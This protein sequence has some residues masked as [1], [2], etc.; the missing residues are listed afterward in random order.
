MKL[1]TLDKIIAL[2]FFL[3]LALMLLFFFKGFSHAQVSQVANPRVRYGASFSGGASFKEFSII[4]AAYFGLQ[5]NQ[6]TISPMPQPTTGFNYGLIRFWDFAGQVEVP[7]VFPTGTAYPVATPGTPSWSLFDPWM[8][9]AKTNN[10][11]V[12]FNLGRTPDWSSS[13]GSRCTGAGTSITGADPSCLGP[14]DYSICAY[15][16]AYPATNAGECWTNIDLSFLGSGPDTSYKTIAGAM[17]TH[18][19]GLS[20][21]TYVNTAIW[22]PWNEANIEGM[23]GSGIVQPLIQMANDAATAIYAANPR[24]TVTTPN[25][26]EWAFPNAQGVAKFQKDYI[27]DPTLAANAQML[28]IHTYMAMNGSTGQFPCIPGPSPTCTSGVA[29]PEELVNLMAAV[30][31]GVPIWSNYQIIASEESWGTRNSAFCDPDMRKAFMRIY[32]IGWAQQLYSMDWYHFDGYN[33]CDTDLAT[34]STGTNDATCAAFGGPAVPGMTGWVECP[35]GIAYEQLYTWMVGNIMD[36]PCSGPYPPDDPVATNWGVWTCHFLNSNGSKALAVW[37]TDPA[38]TCSGLFCPT[39]SY[40]VTGPYT[41]YY[42]LDNNTSHSIGGGCTSSC[43][44]QIGAK[45]ILLHS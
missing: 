16:T 29:P 34:P 38:Y 18:L 22:E 8:A 24:N 13:F 27:A 12:V 10:L 30:R 26:V 45:P 3:W 40:T 37:S 36:V 33:N 2:A 44:V 32:L 42:T 20:S 31:R 28:S 7:F 23:W 21:S 11:Q 17:A 5:I 15:S 6:P 14:A 19:A 4:P 1:K 35:A 43:T 39:M 25:S 41:H 9:F